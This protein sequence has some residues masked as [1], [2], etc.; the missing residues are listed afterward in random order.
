MSVA[1]RL[2]RLTAVSVVLAASDGNDQVDSSASRDTLPWSVE[3]LDAIMRDEK[4]DKNSLGHA[5]V[6]A[7]A[8]LLGPWR[9]RVRRLVEVGIGSLNSRNAAH[10]SFWAKHSLGKGHG[11][12]PGA[13]LRSWSRF[14]P[15]ANITGIDIDNQ[16]VAAV[17][18][19]ARFP[20]VNAVHTNTQYPEK[21]RMDLE[22]AQISNGSC[23]IIIDDGLHTWEGQQNTLVTMWPYLRPGGY[24]FV[25]DTGFVGFGEAM[26]QNAGRGMKLVSNLEAHAI[27]SVGNAVPLPVGTFTDQTH[28]GGA[29]ILL[30]KPTH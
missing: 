15:Y 9:G 8:P 27:F 18:G 21:V 19:D 5:Y 29:L 30:T 2:W 7:Y 14:F 25:E 17:N 13:S 23:D 24:Y 22:I 4:T 12:R 11:Y 1:L 28:F 10:M 20:R 26:A 3:I 6:N 16:I